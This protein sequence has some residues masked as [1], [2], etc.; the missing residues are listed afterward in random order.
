MSGDDSRAVVRTRV[1]GGAGHDRVVVRFIA[2]AMDLS[3]LSYWDLRLVKR[4][5][6]SRL[7]AQTRFITRNGPDVQD[8]VSMLCSKPIDFA[9]GLVLDVAALVVEHHSMT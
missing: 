1:H 6:R 4:S 9:G 2:E 7:P 5:Q 8:I 3:S